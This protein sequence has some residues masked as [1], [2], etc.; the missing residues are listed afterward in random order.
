MRT[1][2]ARPGSVFDVYLPRHEPPGPNGPAP[3]KPVAE[4]VTR[5]C[6]C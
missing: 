2:E 5:C 1:L 4:R 3:P 6:S